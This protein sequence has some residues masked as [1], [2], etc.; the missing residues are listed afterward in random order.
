MAVALSNFFSL[1]KYHSTVTGISIANVAMW[2][3]NIELVDDSDVIL[4][5]NEI[6]NKTLTFNLLSNS[7]VNSKYN[8][9]INHIPYNIKTLLS[10]SSNSGSVFVD[11]TSITVG[12]PNVEETFIIPN[13][14]TTSTS[15]G[16]TMTS[17]VT[18]SSKTLVFEKA[19][20]N[21]QIVVTIDDSDHLININYINF[22][23]VTSGNS[24]RLL[25]SLNFSTQAVQLTG[26]NEL[27]LYA[28]FEQI[29]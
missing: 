16:I 22:G 12:F 20:E 18:A 27:E 28:T 13:A 3:N 2:N 17:T 9:T 10:N 21:M 23:T 26:A 7:E 4:D 24:Q 15:N 8:I 1:A 29:D 6:N 25:H 11:G 19:N 14:S 5:N